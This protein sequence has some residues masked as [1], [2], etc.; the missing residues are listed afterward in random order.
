MHVLSPAP[1]TWWRLALAQGDVPGGIPTAGR[2]L[3]ASLAGATAWD[4]C[5]SPVGWRRARQGGGHTGPIFFQLRE[6][7]RHGSEAA[8]PLAKIDLKRDKP[9]PAPGQPAGV[10]LS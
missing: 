6:R 2:V 5:L 1:T 4:P 10:F 9:I 3:S 7:V 8:F